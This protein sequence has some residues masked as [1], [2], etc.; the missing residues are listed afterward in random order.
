MV[1]DAVGDLREEY[2]L[3]F[4]DADYSFRV[5]QHGWV[6]AVEPRA[7]AWHRGGGSVA[8]TDVPDL[9]YRTRNRLLFSA[10]W[11]P[12]PVRGRVARAAFLLQS[13]ERAFRR[14]VLGRRGEAR[15]LWRAVRDYCLGRVGKLAQE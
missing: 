4:E 9:Y 15:L 14:F 13:S 5:R 2:F 12:A 7:R 3:Y 8:A 10:E 6:V 11:N 1:L